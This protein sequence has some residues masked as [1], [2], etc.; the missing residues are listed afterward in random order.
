MASQASTVIAVHRQWIPCPAGS[1]NVQGTGQEN[2]RQ[3]S[4][5]WQQLRK[6]RTCGGVTRRRT[7]ANCFAWRRWANRISLG[8]EEMPGDRSVKKGSGLL[9]NPNFAA[10]YLLESRELCVRNP[11]RLD[12]FNSPGGLMACLVKGMGPVRG[13][14]GPPFQKDTLTLINR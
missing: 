7:L 13:G 10:T 3:K 9:K 5:S 11:T 2:R 1:P 8:A 12:F 6:H 14:A 4:Q